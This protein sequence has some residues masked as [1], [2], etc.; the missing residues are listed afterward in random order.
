MEV[1]PICLP[2]SPKLRESRFEKKTP[3]VAGWGAIGFNGPTSA[4]LRE[5]QLP[6]VPDEV[7]LDK[8]KSF[9]NIQLDETNICAGTQLGGKD[10]CQGDSGGPLMQPT[11]P[12]EY[13]QIGI[14]S[15]GY[16]CAEPGFPGVYTRVTSHMDWIEEIIK[17]SWETAAVIC[18]QDWNWWGSEI[19]I[20][21]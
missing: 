13:V 1:H 18:D 7:C 11:T 20:W 9:K 16:K 21:I 2:S 4:V 15:F 17:D 10:T 6:V 8:Y 12:T 5:V 19:K 3:F 14:V